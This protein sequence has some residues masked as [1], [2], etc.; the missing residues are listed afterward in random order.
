MTDLKSVASF[1]AKKL[2]EIVIPGCHHA[3]L[4]ILVAEENT[5]SSAYNKYRFPGFELGSSPGFN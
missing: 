2:S 3:G 4:T 5:N 1:A